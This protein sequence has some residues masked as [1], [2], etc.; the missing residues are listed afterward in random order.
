MSGRKYNLIVLRCAAGRLC[1]QLQLL[2]RLRRSLLPGLFHLPVSQGGLCLPP[3]RRILPDRRVL[4]QLPQGLSFDQARLIILQI[5]RH[6]HPLRAGQ[7]LNADRI[8]D[9]PLLVDHLL[10]PGDQLQRAVLPLL[11]CQNSSC[12]AAEIADLRPDLIIDAPHDIR[13]A[14]YIMLRFEKRID[15]ISL[16]G[17]VQT[18]R[19]QDTEFLFGRVHRSLSGNRLLQQFLHPAC[20]SLDGIVLLHEDT[21]RMARDRGQLLQLTL[22]QLTH[23]SSHPRRLPLRSRGNRDLL[24]ARRAVEE[25]RVHIAQLLHLLIRYPGLHQRLLRLH[26]LRCI[27]ILEIRDKILSDLL[28]ILSCRQP[29]HIASE[30]LLPL[31]ISVLT[32]GTSL[33]RTPAPVHAIVLIT[34]NLFFFPLRSSSYQSAPA[35]YVAFATYFIFSAVPAPLLSPPLESASIPGFSGLPWRMWRHPDGC[36]RDTPSSAADV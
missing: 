35:K 31:L 30:K 29:L 21:E 8:Q 23:I 22:R 12:P 11:I 34:D 16:C 15:Q 1:L 3:L 28:Q 27:H 20:L 32:H 25:S 36:F 33:L 17:I 14:G 9:I 2:L 19:T 13:R 5:H 4:R 18:D 26:N 24:L 7:I 6:L 10:N